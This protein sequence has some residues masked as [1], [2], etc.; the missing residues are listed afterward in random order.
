MLF[1]RLFK[2]VQ[3]LTYTGA[4]AKC[5]VALFSHIYLYIHLYFDII[6]KI[7][8]WYVRRPYSRRSTVPDCEKISAIAEK[9][10]FI[11]RSILIV[12][13]QERPKQY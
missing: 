6:K 11:T 10:A 9:R 3:G 13:C 2:L 1:K 12:Y 7:D 8:V 4:Q 5:R